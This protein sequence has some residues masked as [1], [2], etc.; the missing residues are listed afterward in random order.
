M[1]RSIITALAVS[2]IC[3]VAAPAA[4][5]SARSKVHA[6]IERVCGAGGGISPWRCIQIVDPVLFRSVHN[7]DIRTWNTTTHREGK[8]RACEA[9]NLCA[10]SRW[11]G[12]RGI[13]NVK[14]RTARVTYE[15]KRCR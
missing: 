10:F 12:T 14:T 6:A 11:C 1:S 9:F 5:A 4:D 8:G 2:I 3:A 7:P 13:Y 15:S